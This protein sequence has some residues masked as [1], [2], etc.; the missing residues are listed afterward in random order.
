M[1]LLFQAGCTSLNHRWA[2]LFWLLHSEL[3]FPVS[4][5]KLKALQEPVDGDLTCTDGRDL[6][7]SLAYDTP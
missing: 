6:E 5:R 1:L 7:H 2:N 4:L 3:T